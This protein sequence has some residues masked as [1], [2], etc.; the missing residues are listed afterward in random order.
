M[1]DAA[2]LCLG[3]F[4]NEVADG[5]CTACGYD[6]REERSPRL[7]PRRAVL[8]EQYIV[9]R[10]LRVDGE[11]IT[12]LA[13]DI[14]LRRKVDIREHA[15]FTIARRGQDGK[16]IESAGDSSIER[17]NA[18]REEFKRVA[19]LYARNDH[20]NVQRVSVLF[21]ENATVYLVLDHLGGMSLS[22]YLRVSSVRPGP[23]VVLD[24]LLPM[25]D[26]VRVLHDQGLLHPHL[27][28]EDIWIAEGQRAILSGYGGT[29]S[30]WDRDA[31]PLPV[32]PGYSAPELYRGRE[33]GTWTDVYSAGAIAYRLL[34]GMAPPEATDREVRD[35]LVPPHRSAPE[36]PIS[37]GMAV[38]KALALHV[39]QRPRSVSQFQKMLLS[40][41]EQN[42]S[43]ER[44]SVPRSGPASFARLA[45]DRLTT[46][47]GDRGGTATIGFV[48]ILSITMLIAGWVLDTT[49][50]RDRGDTV[51]RWDDTV[52]GAEPRAIDAERDGGESEPEV[53]SAMRTAAFR[54]ERRDVSSG[55]IQQTGR[56]RGATCASRHRLGGR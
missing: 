20:P 52:I 33:T 11:G 26:G 31:R 51:P 13:W 25:L 50:E 1:I 56:S 21:E 10:E 45:K 54:S 43:M 55:D 2:S 22:H 7:L 41:R 18:E 44:Q 29:R 28:P 12:Y 40:V 24:V 6:E 23:A 49:M 47:I 37:L 8:N 46:W 5:R 48:A 39:S 14:Q 30:S 4:V 17:L 42:S 16:T 53:S 35:T 38:L 15:P 36:V 19:K 3:C 27:N 9:G 32:V 34:T